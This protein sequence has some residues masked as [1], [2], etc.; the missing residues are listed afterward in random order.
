MHP[1]EKISLPTILACKALLGSLIELIGEKTQDQ[2]SLEKAFFFSQMNWE[3]TQDINETLKENSLPE[4]LEAMMDLD[5]DAN[6]DV[7]LDDMMLYIKAGISLCEQLLSNSLIKLE[8]SSQQYLKECQAYLSTISAYFEKKI[9]PKAIKTESSMNGP[10]LSDQIIASPLF[11]AGADR[12]LAEKH[13]KDNPSIEYVLRNSDLR[14]EGHHV[15]TLSYKKKNGTVGHL[16]IL[17]QNQEIC[18]Y[19]TDDET[20]TFIP[21]LHLGLHASLQEQI[22]CQELETT[23]ISE[24]NQHVAKKVHFADR[25]ENFFFSDQTHPEIAESASQF[26]GPGCLPRHG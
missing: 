20:T 1:D 25:P 10:S 19:H 3:S 23:A 11:L 22:L 4:A 21:L 18:P 16:R 12:N 2:A 14:I 17:A 6:E 8:R 15:F 7:S 24:K 26:D 13:L 9:T 5:F